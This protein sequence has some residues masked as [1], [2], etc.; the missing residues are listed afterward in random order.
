MCFTG[1]DVEIV[2]NNVL[3]LVVENSFRT[4]RD[5]KPEFERTIHAFRPFE[6]LKWW[7]KDQ[8]YGFNQSNNF[9]KDCKLD[10]QLSKFDGMRAITANEILT[11]KNLQEMK[12]KY[13]Q[14][15]MEDLC[16]Q[17]AFGREQLVNMMWLNFSKN[18][19][20]TSKANG[21]HCQDRVQEESIK[22]QDENVQIIHQEA[23]VVA[24][25][26]QIKTLIKSAPKNSIPTNMEVRVFVHPKPDEKVSLNP[27]HGKLKMKLQKLLLCVPSRI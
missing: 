9:Q 25:H 18:W 21:K 3:I 16:M 22:R 14:Q 4:N 5:N 27:Y 1:N 26:D 2:L 15:I 11:T 13:K 7:N 12:Y 17:N 20:Q 6:T 10:L 24:K 23:P 19:F 8:P